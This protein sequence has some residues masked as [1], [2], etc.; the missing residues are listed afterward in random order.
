[1]TNEKLNT[2][3]IHSHARKDLDSLKESRSL[4]RVKKPKIEGYCPK[5]FP[6]VTT[7]VDAPSE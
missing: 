6:S 4:E 5:G 1:M 7:V 3:R 2:T